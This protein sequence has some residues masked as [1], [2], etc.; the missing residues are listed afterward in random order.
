MNEFQVT[1]NRLLSQSGKSTS[2]VSKLGGVDRAYLVRLLDGEKSAPSMETLLRIWLW[3]SMDPRVVAEYPDFA[4]G[5]EALIYAAA[6]SH[7]PLALAASDA[8][9]LTGRKA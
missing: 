4:Q 2:Q 9:R 3:L 6:M 1:L 7:A 8:R 5:L